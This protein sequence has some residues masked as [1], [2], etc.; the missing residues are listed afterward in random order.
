MKITIKDEK[1]NAWDHLKFLLKV[2]ILLKL[3]NENL[4]RMKPL[5]FP[6]L[7]HIFRRYLITIENK[8][9]V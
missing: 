2:I 6:I 8:N 7:F 3:K 4:K 5:L 1:K 9:K